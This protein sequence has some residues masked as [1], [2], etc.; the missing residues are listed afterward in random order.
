MKSQFSDMIEYLAGLRD[1]VDS[2]KEWEGVKCEEYNR[3]IEAAMS[4][5]EDDLRLY[6][7]ASSSMRI[8]QI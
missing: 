1:R 4:V 2:Q 3:G 6:Q 5:I 8:M 7:Y